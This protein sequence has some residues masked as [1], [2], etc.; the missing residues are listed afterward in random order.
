[1]I[2]KIWKEKKVYWI[3]TFGIFTSLRMRKFTLIFWYC[4]SFLCLSAFLHNTEIM[5]LKLLCCLPARGYQHLSHWKSFVIST[6][7]VTILVSPAD[8]CPGLLIS[9][10]CLRYHWQHRNLAYNDVTP[11]TSRMWTANGG[12]ASTESKQKCF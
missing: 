8:V 2:N 1:M 10:T 5:F 11:L 6:R 12:N 3:T 9:S 4:A 7:S